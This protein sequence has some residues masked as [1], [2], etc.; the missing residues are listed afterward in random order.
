VS[1]RRRRTE[2]KVED[3]DGFCARLVGLVL[4]DRV[5]E[6]GA[7]AVLRQGAA[8]RVVAVLESLRASTSRGQ[9]CSP[10]DGVK[11][12]REKGGTHI[13]VSCGRE[14]PPVGHDDEAQVVQLREVEQ[15]VGLVLA[16]AV[17]C[18]RASGASAQELEEYTRE[19]GDAPWS[20]RWYSSGVYEKGWLLVLNLA[21]L[22]SG[23]P[24]T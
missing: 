23:R 20:Q 24:S 16:P 3:G 5:G 17:G 6:L 8:A 22:V 14:L 11:R 1:E 10:R 18:R 4:L 15:V 12:E 19:R 9:L 13:D 7:R 21:N 2:V